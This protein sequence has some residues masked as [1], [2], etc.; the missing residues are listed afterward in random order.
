M[1]YTGIPHEHEEGIKNKSNAPFLASKEIKKTFF[2]SMML[3]YTLSMLDILLPS[4]FWLLFLAGCARA[5][6]V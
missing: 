4:H 1:H 2:D 6:A 5:A 3:P